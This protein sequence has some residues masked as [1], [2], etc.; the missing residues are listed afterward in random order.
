MKNIRSLILREI[1]HSGSLSRADLSKRLKIGFP[2]I[3][4]E[5]AKMLDD[6][7]LVTCAYRPNAAKGRK[8]LL[9]D[10]NESY[11]FAI[12]IG[13]GDDTL[14][15]G[16]TTVKGSS[17]AKSVTQITDSADISN[18][19]YDG[20]CELMRECSLTFNSIFGI[21][22]CTKD[23]YPQKDKIHTHLSGLLPDVKILFEPADGYLDWG[24]VSVEGLYMFGCAKIIR[25]LFLYK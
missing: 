3:S 8:N 23:E 5:T 1:S 7:I 18:L 4:V 15:I 16:I 24:G 2:V 11:K 17:L 13:I 25:D 22:L 20:I 12:G 10:F 6:G 21:G 19:A 9:L 14:S